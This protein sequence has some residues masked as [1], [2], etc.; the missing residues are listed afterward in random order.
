MHEKVFQKYMTDLMH[1]LKVLF[2]EEKKKINFITRVS[3]TRY[4]TP[5]YKS[6][7]L[8]TSYAYFF[9]SQKVPKF[10]SANCPPQLQTVLSLAFPP[11]SFFLMYGKI[12]LI[13]TR[14]RP[15]IYD[16]HPLNYENITMILLNKDWRMPPDRKPIIFPN[17]QGSHRYF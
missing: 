5:Q 1:K 17:I 12:M 2:P 7:E 3:M 9:L 13:F 15:K 6:T 8:S 4:C 10:L 11:Y 16:K 14:K